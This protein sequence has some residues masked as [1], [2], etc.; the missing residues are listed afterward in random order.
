VALNLFQTGRLDLF[1]MDGFN[2]RP[3]RRPVLQHGVRSV[4]FRPAGEPISFALSTAATGSQPAT[5]ERWELVERTPTRTSSFPLAGDAPEVG[6]MGFSEDGRL[7]IALDDAC[8]LQIWDFLSGAQ[9]LHRPADGLTCPPPSFAPPEPTVNAGPREPQ[10]EKS[11]PAAEKRPATKT[12]R[13]GP[14]RR[15]NLQRFAP[16][17]RVAKAKDILARMKPGERLALVV[18]D[19]QLVKPLEAMIAQE[20]HRVIHRTRSSKD[21][22]RRFLLIERGESSVTE[23]ADIE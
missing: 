11:P 3:K 7:L 10:M 19:R 20:K 22:N 12:R 9:L 6:F 21:P 5:V 18:P 14:D 1:A 17:S 23:S 13:H 15:V 2:G 8:A 4:A 16:E